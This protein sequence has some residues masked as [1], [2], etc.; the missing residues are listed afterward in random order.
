[1]FTLSLLC[2]IIAMSLAL[3]KKY[4]GI[5]MLM[6]ILQ[7]FFAF[8]GYGLSKLPYIVYPFVKITD[9]TVSVATGLTLMIVIILGL[10]LLIPSLILLLRLATD[11]KGIVK[12]QK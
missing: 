5:A 6:M 3:L 12:N 9:T 2:F 1:M 11:N 10:L 4:H 7:L 8:F